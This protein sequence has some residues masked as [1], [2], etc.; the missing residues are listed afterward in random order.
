[1]SPGPVSPPRQVSSHPP[2]RTG[3]GTLPFTQNL[4]SLPIFQTNG[5]E[6]E[7]TQG[8]SSVPGKEHACME[9]NGE[10]SPSPEWREI[11][12]QASNLVSKETAGCRR[13][14]PTLK[15]GGHAPGLLIS[16]GRA[17]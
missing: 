4:L 7:E 12:S 1:M 14:I 17:H 16:S 9:G 3:P 5:K 6:G 2:H 8:G 10:P 15:L 11:R 13:A